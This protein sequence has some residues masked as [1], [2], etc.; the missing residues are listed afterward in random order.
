MARQSAVEREPLIV[1]AQRNLTPVLALQ[2][3]FL[4]GQVVTCFTLAFLCITNGPSDAA[5]SSGPGS[6]VAG[7]IFLGV[8]YAGF[9]AVM[10]FCGLGLLRRSVLARFVLF[11][12]EVVVAAVS[13]VLLPIAGVILTA[14]AVITIV[15]LLLPS[16]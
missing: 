14:A 6:S 16:R 11:G 5:E 12:A 10:L 13:I 1:E 3:L 4:I 9:G 7:L 15:L 2:E 8:L